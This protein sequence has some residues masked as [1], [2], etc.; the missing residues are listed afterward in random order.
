MPGL[1]ALLLCVALGQRALHGFDALAYLQAIDAGRMHN[2]QSALYHP[3]A[4]TWHQ[5]IG[6]TGLPLYESL[7]LLSALAVALGVMAARQGAIAAGFE[8]ARA[9]TAACMLLSL[10][11]VLHCGSV[12]EID[13][14]VFALCCLAWWPWA[15]ALAGGGA[16]LALLAG[17]CTALAALF[18]ASG[19][20]AAVTLCGFAFVW[21]S[22]RR[23]WRA[24]ALRCACLLLAHIGVA[25]PMM[26]IIGSDGHATMASNTTELAWR[27]DLLPGVALHEW[28]LPYLGASVLAL[29]ALASTTWRLTVLGM[30][31][32]VAAYLLLTARIFGALEA[33]T[34]A[35]PRGELGERGAFLLALAWPACILACTHWSLR[36]LWGA[37]AT[38]ALFATVDIWRRDWPADPPGLA[39]GA[40]ALH[41]ETPLVLLVADAQE[42]A[43]IQRRHPSIPCETTVALLQQ[44]DALQR[45]GGRHFTAQELL[46][47]LQIRER[48][49]A[50]RGQRP[51]AT[52]RAVGR[53]HDEAGPRWREAI[54]SLLQDP[55]PPA[56]QRAGLRARRLTRS[57]SR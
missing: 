31:I 9:L 13:A 28:L 3:L 25:L 44:V 29:L 35:L 17:C 49:A 5:L 21:P 54:E 47:G 26:A 30:A 56:I 6:W 1:V 11:A 52:E 24:N 4:W 14:L 19:H 51:L 7:R 57:D 53:L 50:G 34:A 38:G 43:W 16:R 40:A 27:L 20:L 8:P 22:A 12:V 42:Q 46:L 23:S 39:A 32:A 15:G 37:I 48:Q 2:P 36:L 55:A 18:H 10:P 33:T 45:A 41:S